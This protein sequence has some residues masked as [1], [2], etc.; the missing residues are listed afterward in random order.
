[1]G[2]ARYTICIVAGIAAISNA[3]Y[4]SS[5]VDNYM[6][7]LGFKTEKVT[8]TRGQPLEHAYC[9]EL[10]LD[11]GSVECSP[12][13]ENFRLLRNDNKPRLSDGHTHHLE[14]DSPIF[15]V[16]MQ[17]LSTHFPKELLEGKL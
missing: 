11:D 17:P 13:E 5:M 6:K 16:L 1:M 14:T 8:R 2:L 10:L 9:D 3:N 7:G 4:D 12:R 15:G